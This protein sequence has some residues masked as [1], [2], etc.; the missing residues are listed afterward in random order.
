[1]TLFPFLLKLMSSRVRPYLDECRLLIQTLSFWD[2]KIC[3]FDFY[4]MHTSKK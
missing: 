2:M 3:L 4:E 1:M